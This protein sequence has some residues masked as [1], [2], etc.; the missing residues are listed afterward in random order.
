M[1]KLLLLL[2]LAVLP[3]LAA[4]PEAAP[5]VA[6][7]DAAGQPVKLS[8]LVHEKPVCLV[9]WC[10]TCPSCRTVDKGLDALVGRGGNV[11][12]VCASAGESPQT[13]ESF[14]K[15]KSH[16]FPV[17]FDQRWALTQPFGVKA[18]TTALI[19]DKDLRVQYFG[20]FQEDQKSYAKD[21]LDQLAQGQPVAIPRTQQ[22][23]CTIPK[24]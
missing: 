7:T 5:D 6:L 16:R 11:Y 23:G 2:V 9:W 15:E 4:V 18:T 20:R 17:L 21:A 13:V 3:G 12:V 1:R 19:L 10:S 22:Y 8:S 14:M 24:P